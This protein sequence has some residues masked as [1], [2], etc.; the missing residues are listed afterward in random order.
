MLITSILSRKV[1][2]KNYEIN[3]KS[4]KKLNGYFKID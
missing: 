3:M 4:M 1:K 2:I